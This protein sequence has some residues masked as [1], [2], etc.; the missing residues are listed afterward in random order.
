M[1]NYNRKLASVFTFGVGL[2]CLSGLASAQTA[3]RQTSD[4]RTS[5]VRPVNMD[6]VRPEFQ[7]PEILRPATGDNAW[8]AA[9]AAVAVAVKAATYIA[10]NVTESWH[11]GVGL[12]ARGQLVNMGGYD[13]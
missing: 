7:R 9:V 2:L 10:H 5:T 6:I 12:P 3:V 11:P 4:A 13:R 1:K 8:P